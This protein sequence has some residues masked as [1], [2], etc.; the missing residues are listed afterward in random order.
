METGS[1]EEVAA[2]VRRLVAPN[3]SPMTGYGTN[4]YVIGASGNLLVVDPGPAIAGHM[5][6]LLSLHSAKS[7]IAAIVVTHAHLDHSQAAPMISRQTGA[8]TLALG[9]AGEARSELMRALAQQGLSHGGEGIDRNFRPD[10]RLVA[11]QILSGDW[12][13]LEVMHTPGHMAEHICLRFGDILFSGDHAMGWSTSL[14]SPP[15][16]DMGS[17]LASLR[18]LLLRDWQLM[19]PGHGN[20]VRHVSQR[21][22]ELLE[23]RLERE[24]QIARALSHAPADC[25]TL[26]KRIYTETPAALLPAAARNILAHLID[27]YSRNVVSC[28]GTITNNTVFSLQ[29]Q[30]P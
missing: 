23:H 19:L 29:T 8:P 26:A 30:E 3:P 25:A 1:F 22:E 12:G 10:E 7:R 20:A 5:D 21:L 18:A 17:Y 4:S 14:V 13:E 6:A 15:D 2:G 27:L 16:G 11:G 28:S 9:A 24:Q